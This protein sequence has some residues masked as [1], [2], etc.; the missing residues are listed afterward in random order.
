MSY[1][2]ILYILNLYL[3]PYHHLNGFIRQYDVMESVW[4]FIK[5]CKFCYFVEQFAIYTILLQKS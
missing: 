2:F 5:F 4:F 1:D 3:F